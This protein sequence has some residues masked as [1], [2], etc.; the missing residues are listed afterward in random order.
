M[1]TQSK[2]ETLIAQAASTKDKLF[3]AGLRLFAQKGYANVGIRELCR[4]V[5]IKESSFY[6]HYPG[7]ESLFE[8]ILTWFRTAS[9]Q[10]V[11][12]DAEI[13]AM[14][15]QGDVRAFFIDNMRRFSAITSNVVYHT[16]LQIVLTESFLHPTA[17]EI[18]RNNL[19]YLR[20]DYTVQVLRGLMARGAIRACDAENV[21]AEY[22]Y[23]LK[24]M[25]D[26]YLLLQFWDEDLAQINARIRA[27]IDF[28]SELLAVPPEERMNR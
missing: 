22:Y 1:D 10:V 7:K 28:F 20:R 27:H 4:M 11:M 24:G 17:A 6:N 12:H 13:H 14:I 18:A 26:E 8:A 5:G 9:N 25:L 23:A 21:T 2:F 15:E 16:A 19:Y 3:Y